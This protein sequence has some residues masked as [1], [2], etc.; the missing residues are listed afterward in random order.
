VEREV[1]NMRTN[2]AVKRNY[3]NLIQRPALS[4]FAD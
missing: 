4:V 2:I 3:N 1:A